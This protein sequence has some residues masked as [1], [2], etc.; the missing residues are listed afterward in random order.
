MST[1]DWLRAHLADLGLDNPD[2][3]SRAAH[4]AACPDC[5]R[6]V[7]RGLDDD[8]CAGVATV[9]PDEI[10]HIGE[11][12]AL[13]IGLLTYSIRRSASAGGKRQWN[14]DWRSHQETR[15]TPNA[16]VVAQHKCGMKIPPAANPI[17][18]PAPPPHPA[19]DPNAIPF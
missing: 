3:I 10:D 14:L 2:G 5:G 9:D 15:F 7:L 4:L 8:R 12:L 6:R 13:K 16:P 1:P 11:Y 19:A 18:I 17:G